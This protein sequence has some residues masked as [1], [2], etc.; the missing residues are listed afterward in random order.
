MAELKRKRHNSVATNSGGQLPGQHLLKPNAHAAIRRPDYK[1]HAIPTV[2]HIVPPITATDDNGKKI[3]KYF[4]PYRDGHGTE[5]LMH[6]YL[7]LDVAQG[8]GIG[9]DRKSFILC[10]SMDET[11]GG[12]N[13]TSYGVL[14][15]RISKAVKNS[16]GNDNTV[17]CGNKKIS[18]KLWSDLLP[19]ENTSYEAQAFMKPTKAKTGFI[20]IL[21]MIDNGKLILNKD[22]GRMLGATPG[23]MAQILM[24]SG[25][26]IDVVRSKATAESAAFTPDNYDWDSAYEFGDF[27]KLD[28]SGKYMVMYNPEHHRNA[29]TIMRLAQPGSVSA[30]ADED[31]DPTA[32]AAGGGGKRQGFA[33]YEVNFVPKVQLPKL[34]GGGDAIYSEKKMFA[35]PS[36]Q[37]AILDNYDEIWRYFYLPPMEEQCLWLA[38]AY[39]TRPE[40]LLYGWADN[41]EYFTDEV[42][43]VLRARVQALVPSASQVE[44]DVEEDV[45]SIYDDEDDDEPL[46]IVSKAPKANKPVAPKSM[47][48]SAAIA[49]AAAMEDDDDDDDSD[50][51]MLDDDDD[52]SPFGVGDDLDEDEVAMMVDA[53]DDDELDDDEMDED[54]EPVE[55]DEDDDSSMALILA[56]AKAAEEA[57]LAA[58]A[59]LKARRA[60]KA[61]KAAKLAKATEA[62]KALRATG[63]TAAPTLA[64]L[65]KRANAAKAKAAAAV[66]G[67]K[68]RKVDGLPQED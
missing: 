36:I 38:Q 25:S 62:A 45:N 58:E 59:E 22:T 29:G 35:D 1:K 28:G 11:S 3:Q 54:D 57:R 56:Q 21:L 33:S 23:D 52:V 10:D 34:S 7:I 65:E 19:N 24:L 41:S 12:V 27:T 9:D 8:V 53:S 55:D 50:P 39:R 66:G 13:E 68:R 64:D 42:N 63:K 61:A 18:P 46:Q 16:A 14:Y 49:A 15:R 2:G 37:K 40:L 44:D 20:P 51:V 31:Y 30:D 60:R 43:A 47:A 32:D 4:E 67:K 48:K 5:G 17:R 26:A 6:W